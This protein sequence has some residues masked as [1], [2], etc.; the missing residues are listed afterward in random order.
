MPESMMNMTAVSSSSAMTKVQPPLR[1]LTAAPSP[2]WKQF[3]ELGSYGELLLNWTGRE[4]RVRYKQ[5]VLG[6]AWAIAQPFATM[7]IFTVIFSTFFKLPSDG[8]PYPI[9]SYS[10]LLFWT[11]FQSGVTSGV[12]SVVGSA[13]LL[14]KIYFPR[15]IF[16]LASLLAASVD[17]GIASTILLAMMVLYRVPLSLHLLWVPLIL[18][19]QVLFMLGL[20]LL[21]SALNVFFRDVRFILTLVLQLWTYATPIIYPLSSVPEKIRPF[22]VLNPMAGIVDA[23]RGAFLQARSPNPLAFGTAAMVAVAIFLFGYRY[24]KRAEMRFADVI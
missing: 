9:F 4:L 1:E 14:T 19:V 18:L 5:S 13:G 2:L 12:Q 7:V 22:Y 24:F 16:P 21:L 3:Q 11:F 23:Y 10:A 20:S 17:L 6:A 8:I 15:E